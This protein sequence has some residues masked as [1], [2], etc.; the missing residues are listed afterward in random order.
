MINALSSHYDVRLFGPQHRFEKVLK[1]ADA[2]AFP[3]GIGD[4]D[5]WDQLAKRGR[6]AVREFVYYGG[7]YL[8][9]CMGAYWAGHHYFDLL[10]GIDAVQYIKRPGAEITKDGWHTAVVDWRGSYERMFFWD[11]T[12]F[13]DEGAGPFKTVASYDNGD[14]MA[15]I[16]DNVGLIGCHPESEEHWYKGDLKEDWHRGRHHKLLLKFVNKLMEN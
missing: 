14:P 11:G 10:D 15:I 16:Q 12:A 1:E 3:G 9:I 2:V 13:V 5:T 4:S 8:G 7:K 6:H